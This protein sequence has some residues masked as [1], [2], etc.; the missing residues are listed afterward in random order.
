[1]L[2][3][4]SSTL[5]LEVKFLIVMGYNTVPQSS[6]DKTLGCGYLCSCL[7][8]AGRKKTLNQRESP[9]AISEAPLTIKAN[10]TEAS[11]LSV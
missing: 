5:R 11:S 8:H 10:K 2:C 7:E 3:E 4:A 6:P 9:S 1:M